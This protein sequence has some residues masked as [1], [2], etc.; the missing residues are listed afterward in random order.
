MRRYGE[1]IERD[2]ADRGMDLGQLWR[3]RRF[4]YILNVVDGLPRASHIGQAQ[5]DDPDAFDP[6]A[7]ARSVQ[8]R[9]SVRHFDET[10][11][12][13]MRIHSTLEQSLAVA[14]E[15]YKPNPIPPPDTAADRYWRHRSDEALTRASSILFANQLAQ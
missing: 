4:R 1:A 6:D 15:K 7:P 11:V 13:L 9:P 10:N 14:A 12:L 3:E 5:A 8:W 2:L